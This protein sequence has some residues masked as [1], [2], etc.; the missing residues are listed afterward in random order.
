MAT[1]TVSH[2]GKS[3]PGQKQGKLSALEDI[4]FTVNEGEFLVLLGPSGCGKSTL[5]RLIAGLDKPSSGTIALGPGM[6]HRDIGFVFQ[7]FALLPW[8]TIEQN[9]ALGLVSRGI[10]A[11]EARPAV[12][13]ML[14]RLGLHKFAGAFPREL[15]GGMQQRVGL[16]RA[17]VT[18]P[19]LLLLD[20]PF[21]ALDSFTAADLRQEL[22]RLWVEHKFTVI[23]VSHLVTEA[24]ELAD[25]VIVFTP[26]PGKVEKA[27]PITLPRP[28]PTRTP[29]FYAFQDELD[30]II[31]P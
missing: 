20:E 28:R 6:F 3:Y 27:M 13:A 21:S 26:R 31:R 2:V 12:M 8:L 30:T 19:K 5:L 14:E 1:V 11:D 7:N 17:L 23:M 10:P 22:Q 4:S 18:Q 9:V 24:I 29:S 25:R 16:A 15:S